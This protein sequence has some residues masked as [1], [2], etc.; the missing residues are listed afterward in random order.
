MIPSI[1]TICEDLAA[2][3]ITV[4]QAMAWLQEH[5][6]VNDLRDSFAMSA[7]N[8]ECAAQDNQSMGIAVNDVDYLTSAQRAYKFADAMLKAR[9]T[10]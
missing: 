1:A 9:A 3:K 10:K 6:E 8:G 5:M 2:G 4:Q 7:L